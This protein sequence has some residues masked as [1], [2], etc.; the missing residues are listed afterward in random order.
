M[1]STPH[2]SHFLV[3]HST[4]FNITL[5]LAQ[6][7]CVWRALHFTPFSS[8]PHALM[9][10][11]GLILS[12]NLPSTLCFPSSRSSSFSFSWSSPSS[13]MMWGTS[14]LR[15]LANEDL[16][17][18]AQND[19]LTGS[20]VVFTEQGSSASQMT[21]AKVMDILSRL[22]GCTGPAADAVSAY[23]QV[24][25]EDAPKLLKHSQ[26]GM[27]RHVDSSTTT[28]NGQNHGPVW[29]IQSFLLSEICMVILWQDC[30]GRGNFEKIH[31]QHGW[32]KVSNWECSFVHSEKGLFLSVYVDDI[33]LDH[34]VR[35]HCHK[36]PR[37]AW[38]WFPATPKFG[39]NGAC[40]FVR[41]ELM[42][43][44]P[45]RKGGSQP[46][47][48]VFAAGVGTTR[49]RPLL[50]PLFL[51]VLSCA[52][53]GFWFLRICPSSTPRR[54]LHKDGLNLYSLFGCA[55]LTALVHAKQGGEAQLPRLGSREFSPPT[56]PGQPF[57][58]VYGHS[59]RMA[60]LAARRAPA[61]GAFLLTQQVHLCHK[62]GCVCHPSMCVPNRAKDKDK[63]GKAVCRVVFALVCCPFTA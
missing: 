7:W 6:V 24:K 25:M 33:K 8:H 37:G 50:L 13:S 61:G 4:H 26:I 20:Y 12:T 27:S 18:L 36:N 49:N 21:A 28:Q 11:G 42:V 59:R 46:T 9:M 32:E 15:T 56:F 29:K 1:N 47:A 14:T 22:P 30:Y 45:P 39:A 16:G 53:R 31:L 57:L 5:T 44:C 34:C 48:I 55:A 54:R 58:Q 10:C 40:Q 2:T 35:L 43:G 63:F 3:L 51:Q 60:I 41:Q 38:A 62:V 52:L 19:P 23:T 17:T